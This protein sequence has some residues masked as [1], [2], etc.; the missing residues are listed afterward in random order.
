MGNTV[1]AMSL[2]CRAARRAAGIG[3]GPGGGGELLMGKDVPTPPWVQGKGEYAEVNANLERFLSELS[4]RLR[5]SP[6]TLTAHRNRQ[7]DMV[8]GT[9]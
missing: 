4:P 7:T 5:F 6:A 3:I 1:S 9:F 8:S 2:W